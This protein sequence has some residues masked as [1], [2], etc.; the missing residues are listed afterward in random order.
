MPNTIKA[1]VA[2]VL[3]IGASFC[4]AT[5]YCVVPINAGATPP[6]TD[7]SIAATNIQEVVNGCLAGD[8][9]YLTNGHYY[10]TGEV[11]IA[12]AVTVKS[13]NAGATDPTN[14]I[15]DGNNYAGKPVTNRCLYISA[16]ATIDGLMFTNGFRTNSGGGLCTSGIGVV[17][18]TNCIITGNSVTSATSIYLGGGGVY[19]EAA[20]IANC[21]ILGNRAS[22]W[23]GGV[24]FT[25]TNNILK[26]SVV[27]WNFSVNSGAGMILSGMSSGRGISLADNCTFISN[28]CNA[29]SVIFFYNIVNAVVSNCVIRGNLNGSAFC[30]HN[31]TGNS[32]TIVNCQII[33]NYDA[34]TAPVG[35][36]ERWVV[37]R[38]CLM[39]NNV[40]KGYAGAMYVPLNTTGMVE[41]CTIVSNQGTK[42]GGIYV[43]SSSAGRFYALNTIISSNVSTTTATEDLCFVDAEQTNKFTNCCCPT[44]ALPAGQGNIQ[45]DPFLVN[46]NSGNYRLSANSPCINAGLNQYW[47]TNAFDLDGN[48]RLDQLNGRVDMGAYEFMHTIT[49]ISGH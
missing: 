5:N 10:L 12:T 45:S 39:A 34:P 40:S 30:S 13:Y 6:Y 49:L 42:S 11:V 31:Q 46:L 9:I 48:R 44:V 23:G 16:A 26:D 25:G 35:Y 17:L 36:L 7:W 2:T 14:T 32:N 8:T 24:F 47:M 28:N 41:S 15:L 33:G 3:L 20:I 19:A 18:L 1:M 37:Y 21:Q 29:L 43:E 38:N 27:G 22:G 4:R